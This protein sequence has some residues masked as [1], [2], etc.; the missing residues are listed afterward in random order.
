M[1][2]NPIELTGYKAEDKIKI[3][4]KPVGKDAP[5]KDDISVEFPGKFA[6]G[7]FIG[8]LRKRQSIK[9]E[10]SLY[11]F[12]M[13]AFSPAPNMLLVDLFKAY[14]RGGELIL[15]CASSIAWG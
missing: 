14:G 15:S 2:A 3:T 4:V 8:W 10:D 9:P 7:T 11:M 1:D 13:S 12:C 5:L 6:L